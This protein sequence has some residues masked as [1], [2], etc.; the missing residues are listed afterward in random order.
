MTIYIKFNKF[1]DLI[2]AIA[3]DNFLFFSVIF[4]T[5]MCMQN[6]KCF[7]FLSYLCMSY[8][9]NAS[10]CNLKLTYPFYNVCCTMSRLVAIHS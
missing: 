9:A 10:M 1:T 5:N 2:M 3:V 6:D 8:D 7:N 4:A